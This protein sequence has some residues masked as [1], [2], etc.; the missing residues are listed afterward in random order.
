METGSRSITTGRPVVIRKINRL[1]FQSDQSPDVCRRVQQDQ[2][3]GHRDQTLKCPIG[4]KDQT[5]ARTSP[6]LGDQSHLVER[7]PVVAASSNLSCNSISQSQAMASR[8]RIFW[9]ERTRSFYHVG[10][11][12]RLRLLLPFLLL[13]QYR[14]TC[15]C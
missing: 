5:L 6:N 10:Q 15:L 12:P 13:S 3:I 14:L 11:F 8:R 9:F 7:F 2:S 4:A 1:K